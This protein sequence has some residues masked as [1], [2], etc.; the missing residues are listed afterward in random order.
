MSYAQQYDDRPGEWFWMN[1]PDA[2]EG[3][4]FEEWYKNSAITDGNPDHDI[5]LKGVANQAWHAA[6]AKGGG[7]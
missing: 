2:R 4:E 3:D 5:L 1:P 6:K 7:E